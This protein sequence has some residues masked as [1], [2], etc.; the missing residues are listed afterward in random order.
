MQ[1]FWRKKNKGVGGVGVNKQG[2]GMDTNIVWPVHA[3]KKKE[4]KKTHK[5]LMLGEHA[6]TADYNKWFDY[7]IATR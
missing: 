4:E 5:S 6:A 7:Y 1:P 3:K 2:K